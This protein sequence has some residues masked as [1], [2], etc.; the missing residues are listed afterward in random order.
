MLGAHKKGRCHWGPS[1]FLLHNRA[2]TPG[3]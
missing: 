1:L 2:T 3:T